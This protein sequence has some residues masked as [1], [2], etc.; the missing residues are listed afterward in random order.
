MPLPGD[1]IDNFT[2]GMKATGN[3]KLEL[4]LD[5][6][7]RR[8]QDTKVRGEFQLQKND[9]Y[10]FEGMPPVTQASG[11][12]LLTESSITSSD[13]VGT[14]RVSGGER[15]AESERHVLFEAAALHR[16]LPLR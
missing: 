7:I 11:R 16:G 9:V 13:L 12:L 4:A 2:R 15:P 10:L 1:K 8:L 6:P 14:A 3:G 5:L